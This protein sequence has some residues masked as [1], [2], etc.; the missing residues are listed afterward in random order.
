MSSSDR[1]QDMSLDR[2]DDLQ[3][4]VGCDVAHEHDA[5]VH[6]EVEGGGSKAAVDLADGDGAAGVVQDPDGEAE[7]DEEVRHDQVLQ[8]DGDAAGHVLLLSAEVNPQR[9][10]VEDQT[11]YENQSV[12]DHEENVG[13]AVGRVTGG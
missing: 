13:R 11:H 3:V 9:E 7:A 4:P 8:V 6:V 5:G 1:L 10:A 2:M 12:D